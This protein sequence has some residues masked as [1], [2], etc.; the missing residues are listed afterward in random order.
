M[1]LADDDTHAVRGYSIAQI[2]LHWLIAILVF[3]QLIFGESMTAFVDAAEEGEPV[4]ALDAKLATVHYY[5]GIA[6]LA[7]VVVRLAL[8]LK[9]GVPPPPASSGALELAGRISHWL[10][11]VLLVAVPITGLL[12]YY[13]GD[14]YG[15]FHTWAKPV[16][17]AL[18]ALHVAA[19]LY[20][21]FWRKDG[22]LMR[23]L[24]AQ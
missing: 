20:H 8:R 1:S 24:K 21:Q 3:T 9:N 5:F 6:I 19:S 4:S 23:M 12:G 11:Y 10:F 18:I 7:L 15:E 17:I 16:F 14:P 22:L 13:V 2:S